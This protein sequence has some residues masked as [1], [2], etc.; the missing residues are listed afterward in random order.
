MVNNNI[1]VN[2]ISRETGHK[3]RPVEVRT[4]DNPVNAK[5]TANEVTV[6]QGQLTADTKSKPQKLTDVTQVK[7]IKRNQAG[8]GGATTDQNATGTAPVDNTKTN[9]GTTTGSGQQPATQAQ[10]QQTGKKGK[11]L[12]NQNASTP[13]ASGQPPSTQAQ[14]QQSGKKRKKQQDQNA[15]TP[16]ASGQQPATQAQDQQSGNKRKKL[17][18]GADQATGSTGQAPAVQG[19]GRKAKGQQ[20][21]PDA[22]ANAPAMGNNGNGKGNGKGKKQMTCD[23]N[24]DANCAPAQ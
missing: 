3:V 22:N 1:D 4:T 18:P 2:I 12:Q 10:G 6:F 16:D 5:A 17:Q 11:K 20:Q 8:N 21:P 13:D 15:S 23:P 14:D 9:A 7:K 19:N 24:T